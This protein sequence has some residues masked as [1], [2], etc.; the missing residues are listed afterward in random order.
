MKKQPKTV[1]F[2]SRISLPEIAGSA[3]SEPHMARLPL[4]DVRPESG[5]LRGQLDLMN[6]GVTGRL[7]EYGP[8]FK[9]DRNG[10]L[11]PETAAGWEEIPYWFRGFYP[12][13]VLTGDKKHLEL[14]QSYVEAL[15]RSVQA[16]GWFGPAYLKDSGEVDGVPTPDLF[17]HM[18]LLDTLILYFEYSSDERVLQLMNGFFRF[19][20]DLP[21]NRFLP[22]TRT[23]L[24]WQKIRGGDMLT[25]IY[26]YYRKCGEN[27]LLD[28]ADRFYRNI[29]RSSTP[30]VAYHAVDFAQRFAY[31][32]IFAQQSHDP[33]DLQRAEDAYL[34]VTKIWGQLPRG[35][36]AADEQV[37]EGCTDPRQGYE[38]CGM[39]ELAKN[40]Y[41]LGRI[42]GDT[43]YADRAEDMMLNH[44]PASFSPSY[45]QLHYVTSANLPAMTNYFQHPICNESYFFRRSHFLMTPN[46]R[47]C[48]HNTG[49]GWPWYAMNLWQRSADCGLVAWLYA[50]CRVDTLLGGD[51]VRLDVKTGYPFFGKVEVT[52]LENGRKKAFPLYFRIPGWNT[53]ARFFLNGRQISICEKKGGFAV[54]N[55]PWKEGDRVSVEFDLPIVFRRWENNGSVS[56]DRGALTYSVRI[57]EDWRVPEGSAGQYDHPEPHLFENYEVL[58][59]TPWNYGLCYDDL[60]A[61]DAVREGSVDEA[62]PDQPWTPENAPVRLKAKVRRIPEWRMED[63]L[64]GELQTSPAFSS[65]EKEEVE[66]IPLG[67]A[68]LRI[69]C[70][71]TVTDDEKIGARWTPAPAHTEPQT[72]TQRYP[73]PY[74]MPKKIEQNTVEEP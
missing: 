67:C 46:N 39:V 68:R 58:P 30:Y 4:G 54:L 49:M 40:F 17:P 60:Q 42:S 26:W 27:W 51:R 20:R 3:L 25:P 13:A 53:R 55:L 15:F 38:P 1:T 6:T 65:C 14:A 11:Y 63:D 61:G 22:A 5:W 8:F 44:F 59:T 36:I 31:S 37:R 70:L 50:P 41:E 32:G 74:P 35:L 34:A 16:D 29:W 71:P 12:L 10:F 19:C 18:M 43:L 47:C 9:P 72:R 69:S 28:L 23:R 33:A 56:V 21:D 64:A 66:L 24:M 62:V 52:V 2:V 73:T 57:E 45:Q 48:G 7:P